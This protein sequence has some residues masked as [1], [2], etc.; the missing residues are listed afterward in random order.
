MFEKFFSIS[1][2]DP[3]KNNSISCTI[4]VFLSFLSFGGLDNLIYLWYNRV[5]IGIIG[6]KTNKIKFQNYDDR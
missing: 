3:V 1:L 4:P 6:I 5:T 2:F